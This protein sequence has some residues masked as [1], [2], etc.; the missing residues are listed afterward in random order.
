MLQ[1]LATWF[2]A[3]ETGEFAFLVSF[4]ALVAVSSLLGFLTYAK[5]YRLIED[6]PS[7]K[8]RSAPQGFVQLEGTA[9][10]LPGPGIYSRLTQQPCV[11]HRYRI[12]EERGSGRNRRRV[13]IEQGSSDDL[14]Q[15]TDET[16]TCVIDPTGARIIAPDRD[17]WRTDELSYSFNYPIMASRWRG[18]RYYYTEERLPANAFMLVLGEFKTR[19]HEGQTQAER[20]RDLLREWKNDPAIL[21]RFAQNPKDGFTL[22]EWDQVRAHAHTVAQQQI[23]KETHPDAFHVVGRGQRGTERLLVLSA[24]TEYELV[25][26]YRRRAYAYA[27]AGSLS[28]FVVFWALAVRTAGG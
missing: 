22:E 24:H 11:W 28:L 19:Y 21:R 4:L 18:G 9:Q 5:R 3:A 17:R 14:F 6:T 12:E 1:N 8:I 15:L 2:A 23:A 13:V 20:V 26:Y 16:G 25:N 27:V 10:W 7:A